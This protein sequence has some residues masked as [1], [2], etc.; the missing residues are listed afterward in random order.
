M[1]ACVLRSLFL[2]SHIGPDYPAGPISFCWGMTPYWLFIGG[3]IWAKLSVV[4]YNAAM[5][6]AGELGL[7]SKA[8]ELFDK[9]KVR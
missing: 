3:L 8:L 2:F 5:H 6:A 7:T 4:G 9:M 1:N